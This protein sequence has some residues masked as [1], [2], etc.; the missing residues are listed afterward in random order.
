M[1]LGCNSYSLKSCTRAQ[2]F[3]HMRAVGFGAVELWVGHVRD[4][5][6]RPE[7]VA[8][9]AREHGLE[10]RA[11]CVG[12]LFDL[13]DDEVQRRLDRALEYGRRLGVDLVTGILDRR[14]LPLADRACMA[15]G[16]RF[17]IE[18]HWYAEFARPR[19]YRV[20][21]GCSPAIGVNI[22]T[23]HFAYLG[24]DLAEAAALLGARTFNVHLKAVRPPGTLGRWRQRFGRDRR[25]QAE[26]PGDGDGLGTFV[27]ALG[28]AGYR[29][30][31]AVE[32]EAEDFRVCDLERWHARGTALAALRPEAA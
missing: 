13:P 4:A 22:D 19:D 32:H 5:E 7:E 18:N 17:A 29:G 6:G 28:R 27:A 14:S 2:A 26:L 23:G 31:L 24:C 21:D 11:Y 30:M 8:A 15:A 12:G 1:E 20:L 25:M 16:M 9:E 3:R 10:I